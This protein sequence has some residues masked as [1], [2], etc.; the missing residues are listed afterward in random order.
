MTLHFEPAIS[1][2][3]AVAEPTD[4]S[5]RLRGAANELV[6]STAPGHI[7]WYSFGQRATRQSLQLDLLTVGTK[8]Q[9]LS[10]ILSHTQNLLYHINVAAGEVHAIDADTA[11]IVATAHALSPAEVS[12]EMS[13]TYAH[14]QQ[15]A[16]LSSDG[17][18]LYLID[19]YEG[20]LFVL[21]SATL[22]TQAHWLPQQYLRAVCQL[23]PN[24]SLLGIGINGDVLYGLSDGG[25]L[26]YVAHVTGAD[27]FLGAFS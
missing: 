23:Q 27:G 6:A 5:H 26:K 22:Q 1:S 4:L 2:A 17:K 13:R 24:D 10:L 21:D 16:A 20:G 18:S 12:T 19:P 25:Q 15:P 7:E 11:D 3:P 9:P 8:G 14:V